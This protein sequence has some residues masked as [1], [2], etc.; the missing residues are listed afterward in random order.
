Y[1]LLYVSDG[2]VF[3]DGTI[4]LYNVHEF[5]KNVSVVV[6]AVL[7]PGDAAWTV[8]DEQ[9]V[10][11]DDSCFRSAP[12]LING[13]IVFAADLGHLC[14]VKLRAAGGL[15]DI[16]DGRALRVNFAEERP[17]QDLYMPPLFIPQY[18]IYWWW[19]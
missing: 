4:V 10:T 11:S 6:A 14:V 8:I 19:W 7:R 12:A 15:A 1:S 17:R 13:E 18:P 2:V 3:A 5:V 16:L 9:L